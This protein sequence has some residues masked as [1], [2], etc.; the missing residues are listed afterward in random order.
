MELIDFLP[1]AVAVIAA[2]GAWAAQRSASS[3]SQSNTAVSGRLQAEQGA[4]ERARAFD[5]QTIQRQDEELAQV[6]ARNAHLEEELARVKKRLATL[7]R[8]YPDLERT[9]YEYEQQK[10]R[11]VQ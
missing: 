11:D 2:L 5:I 9:I 10:R 7:E 6:I 4:Y 1:L 8:I 3:A